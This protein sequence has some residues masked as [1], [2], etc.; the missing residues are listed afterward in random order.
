MRGQTVDLTR[1]PNKSEHACV[2][3][4]WISNQHK[5]LH[6]LL[7][8]WSQGA[9]CIVTQSIKLPENMKTFGEDLKTALMATT[10]ELKENNLQFTITTILWK[11]N[12]NF[13]E[14]F[15]KVSFA[16]EIEINQ[17]DAPLDSLVK[18]YDI[19]ILRGPTL[20]INV[21]LFWMHS[22]RWLELSVMITP[23]LWN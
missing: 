6:P 7:W 19:A 18:P 1:A 4:K 14:V 17:R 21:N 11:L 8:H 16:E 15:Q 9:F 20:T 5:N 10:P 23:K 13:I 22:W 3:V 12:W 2:V